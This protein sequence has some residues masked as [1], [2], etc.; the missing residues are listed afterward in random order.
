MKKVLA[1]ILAL[2]MCLALA[3]CGK[4]ANT[5]SQGDSSND[6][7]ATT[8]VVNPGSTPVV[9]TLT[10]A[11]RN[12]SWDLSPWK[13]NGSSA[14]TM[15]LMIYGNLFA[16]PEFGTPLEDMQ[17]DLAKSVTIS[18]DNLTATIELFD[19]IHDS[20]GNEIT[21]EDVVFSYEKA[22][23]VGSVYAKIATVLKSIS[24]EDK[25][26][27]KMELASYSPGNW[28][29]LLANC[30]IVS[31]S[32]YESSS[33]EEKASDPACTGAYKI[34]ENAVGTSVTM[35]A[36]VISGRKMN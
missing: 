36:L 27:V 29:F 3:A 8:D 9:D 4:D 12:S 14:N 26:T 2:A 32:W 11:L 19:Y 13:H 5:G 16:N 10:Y 6:N 35:A 22:P 7:P 15:W 31:K 23:T 20:K 17:P 25:Y 21:A 30:P 33:D 34:E 18:E 28:E 1:L 24:A